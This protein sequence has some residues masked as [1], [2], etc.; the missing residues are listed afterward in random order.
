MINK[1][2]RWPDPDSATVTKDMLAPANVQALQSF[3]GLANFY[4]IFI[5][6]M[7]NL[8]A[9]LNELLKK[10]ETWT[11]NAKLHSKK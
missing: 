5:K 1:D 8:I 6:N 9:P 3:L 4:Q 11:W 10:D 7:H 2:G